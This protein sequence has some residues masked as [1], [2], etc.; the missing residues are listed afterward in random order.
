MSENDKYHEDKLGGSRS[1]EGSWVIRMVKKRI[2]GGGDV[3]L[4]LS[5]EKEIRCEKEI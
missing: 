3:E 1:L 5:C 2:L 4:R